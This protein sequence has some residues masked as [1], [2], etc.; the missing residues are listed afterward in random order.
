[1]STDVETAHELLERLNLAISSSGVHR[2]A[3]LEVWPECHKPRCQ[4]R[5]PNPNEAYAM[6]SH[7]IREAIQLEVQYRYYSTPE[8]EDD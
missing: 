4:H 6:I 2:A 3:V 5:H 1:M 8:E 7:A